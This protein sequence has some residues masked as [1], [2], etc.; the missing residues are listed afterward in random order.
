MYFASKKAYISKNKLSEVEKEK[1]SKN[2]ALPMMLSTIKEE[3][4]P[5]EE[6]QKM[7]EDEHERNLSCEERVHSDELDAGFSSESEGEQEEPVPVMQQ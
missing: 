3:K 5:K 4:A 6:I 7:E 1:V 2:S